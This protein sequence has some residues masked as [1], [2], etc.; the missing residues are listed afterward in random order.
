MEVKAMNRY[1]ISYSVSAEFTVEIDAESQEA[2]EQ[3]II[4]SGKE[5]EGVY[6]WYAEGFGDENTI[7][8]VELVE[9]DVE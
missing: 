6:D 2:A 4:D 3:A 7:H 5:A 9:E 8:S 1:R